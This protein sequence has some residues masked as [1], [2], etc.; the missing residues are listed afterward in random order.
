MEG[1]SVLA[2]FTALFSIVLLLFTR[3]ELHRFT[4][5]G[6]HSVC[7]LNQGLILSPSC[8]REKVGVKKK[9]SKHELI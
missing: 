4:C 1:N 9:R 5:G 2:I 8:V 3:R 6:L 7:C